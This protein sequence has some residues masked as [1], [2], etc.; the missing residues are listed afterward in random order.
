MGHHNLI[1][2]QVRKLREE[3][4]WTQRTLAEK[5]QI[6]GLEI[7]RSS[8]AKIEARLI[9][10]NDYELFYFARAFNVGLRQL[11]HSI[12]QDDPDLH[13]KLVLIMNIQD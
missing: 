9:R 3:R 5:L 12:H 11:F 8:L 6:A 13:D 2:L 1:G 10:V 4:H 7:S